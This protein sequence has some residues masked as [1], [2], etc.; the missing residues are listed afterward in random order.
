MKKLAMSF[1]CVVFC[2][3]LTVPGLAADYDLVINSGRIMDPETKYD[4][5]ANVGITDG[6]I[7][8]I[9]KKKIKGKETIGWGLRRRDLPCKQQVG[10]V[11]VR[12]PRR[13]RCR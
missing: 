10:D 2:L 12:C 8:I 11:A 5:V 4:Q 9:T 3:A 6:K 13:T 1:G 7:A